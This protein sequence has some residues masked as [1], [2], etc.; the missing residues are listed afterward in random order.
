MGL[1]GTVVSPE[2]KLKNFKRELQKS[3]RLMKR[4]INKLK[5]SES[6]MKQEVKRLAQRNE[7]ESMMILCK[8]IVRNKKAINQFMKLDSSLQALQ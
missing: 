5:M 6:K 8:D 7:T 4:Q 1:C 3:S 2:E